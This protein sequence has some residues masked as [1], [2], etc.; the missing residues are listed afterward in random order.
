MFCHDTTQV[1][2]RLSA[3]SYK[4]RL[5]GIHN[6]DRANAPIII[7]IHSVIDLVYYWVILIDLVNRVIMFLQFFR[8]QFDW[9][10]NTLLA[11][12]YP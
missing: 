3:I 5:S 9:D 11:D 2:N 1:T 12:H 6:L 4:H 8:A 10:E 7:F